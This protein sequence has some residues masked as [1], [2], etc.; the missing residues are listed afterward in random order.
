MQEIINGIGDRIRE[1][2]ESR[3]LSQEAFGKTLGL[4]RNTI[5]KIEK[6]ETNPSSETLNHIIKTYKV[7]AD[8]LFDSKQYGSFSKNGLSVADV[9]KVETFI[10]FL[11]FQHKSGTD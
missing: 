2:R 3:G 8:Y 9:Q 6:G 5:M 1:I 7:S 10:D 4:S 11:K